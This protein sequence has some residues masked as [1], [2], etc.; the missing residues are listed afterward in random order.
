MPETLPKEPSEKI[1]EDSLVTALK[2]EI[3]TE[4][5]AETMADVSTSPGVKLVTRPRLA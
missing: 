3:L 2:F 4:N 5:I 1:E